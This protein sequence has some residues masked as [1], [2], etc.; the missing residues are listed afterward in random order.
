MK[1][2]AELDH[3]LFF[4]INRDTS[5]GFFDLLMPWLREP[6]LWIPVYVFLLGLLIYKKRKKAWIGILAVAL[7]VTLADQLASGVF[8]PLFQRP[9]PCHHQGLDQEVILRKES[10]CGGPYGF[11]SSHAANHFAISLFMIGML[12]LSWKKTGFWLLLLWPILIS[13]AQVYVGVHFPGD[14]LAGAILGVFAAWL[15]LYLARL[16]ERKLER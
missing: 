1:E 6:L 14:T 15:C 12:S 11:A 13:F 2:L 4:L 5:N 3:A 10:G 7:S 16:T 9:R 8:K